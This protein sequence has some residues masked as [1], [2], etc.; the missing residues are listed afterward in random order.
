MRQPRVEQKL[1]SELV[2]SG[3]ASEKPTRTRWLANAEADHGGHDT[4]AEGGAREPG[5]G[6]AAAKAVALAD[7]GTDERAR[8][9]KD[10][11]RAGGAGHGVRRSLRSLR[12]CPATG[13]ARHWPTARS[14]VRRADL[15]GRRSWPPS[16]AR[17][18]CRSREP[19]AAACERRIRRGRG[20]GRSR[21]ARWLCGARGRRPAEPVKSCSAR[22]GRVRARSATRPP[23]GSGAA[24][25][26]RVPG[27]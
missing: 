2:A 1:R 11:V 9:G 25:S 14:P 21:G 10:G 22:D 23:Q 4:A 27:S 15:G 3:E 18:R 19:G 12:P 20:G 7:R 13:P 16:P 26:C 17:A 24:C 6:A 5:A 8:P